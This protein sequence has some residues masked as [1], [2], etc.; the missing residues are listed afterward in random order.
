MTRRWAGGGRTGRRMAPS[1]SSADA[2]ANLSLGALNSA[3]RSSYWSYDA[4]ATKT[5][6]KRTNPTRF[7]T[8]PTNSRDSQFTPCRRTPS[9]PSCRPSPPSAT[10]RCPPPVLSRV[11][12]LSESTG[13]TPAQLAEAWDAHSLSRGVDVLDGDTFGGYSLSGRW[14]PGRKAAPPGGANTAVLKN[15]GGLGK[16]ASPGGAVTPTPTGSG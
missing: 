9:G 6:P 10:R 13:L 11:A 3:G 15:A 16:R 2:A 4:N 7:A 14:A 5:Q 8:Q 1:A 12:A